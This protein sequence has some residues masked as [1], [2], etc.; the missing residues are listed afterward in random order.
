MVVLG[1][2]G[3]GTAAMISTTGQ[4][5]VMMRSK[6][7]TI[8]CSIAKMPVKTFDPIDRNSGRGRSAKGTGR[9]KINKQLSNVSTARGQIGRQVAKPRNNG[10]MPRARIDR[11]QDSNPAPIV[12]RR[13]N[14][15]M[16]H[17]RTGHPD[18]SG[19]MQVNEGATS[20]RNNERT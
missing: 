5:S 9:G 14:G 19:Q 17:A 8:G 12:K 20:A 18:S 3:C 4:M 2:A 16:R 6:I 10:L 1:A 11:A 15:L 13:S 7:G